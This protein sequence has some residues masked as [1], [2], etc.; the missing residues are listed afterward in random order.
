MLMPIQ[1]TCKASRPQISQH[2]LIMRYFGDFFDRCATRP[3]APRG[4]ALP[5][6]FAKWVPPNVTTSSSPRWRTWVRGWWS[7]CPSC[8]I[9]PH[10][11]QQQ[12]KLL[13][14]FSPAL[15]FY[16]AHL[17]SDL[18]HTRAHAQKET[19]EMCRNQ[20]KEV[21]RGSFS[22]CSCMT[23]FHLLEE[24]AAGMRKRS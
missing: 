22:S 15:R 1:T 5:P 12:Q 17:R 24:Y 23:A 2:R 20:V 14:I 3:N 8:V 19:R 16:I 21:D 18:I 9:Y 13:R 4:F 6:W 11:Q 7:S 10:S